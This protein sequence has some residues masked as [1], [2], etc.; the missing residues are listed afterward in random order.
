[1]KNRILQ[2]VIWALIAVLCFSTAC[3]K[4]EKESDT[5]S[6][7]ATITEIGNGSMLVTPVEG[8]AELRS[9]DAFRLPIQNMPPSP[10]PKVGDTVEIIYKGDI[11][12]TYPAGL[13]EIVSI[14]VIKRAAKFESEFEQGSQPIKEVEVEED[15]DERVTFRAIITEIHS[16][17]MLV[18]PVEGSAELR[19]SDVFEVSLTYLPAAPEPQ[20]GDMVEITYNGWINESD[21]AG[22]EKIFSIIIVKEAA[23]V[24][25][26]VSEATGP[27]G[28]IMVDV[29]E[30]WSWEAF[31]VDSDGLTYGQYGLVLKPKDAAGG[32]LEIV[33]S[34]NF[35]VCGTGLKEEEITLAGVPALRGVYDGGAHWDFIIYHGAMDHVVA[36]ALL[37]ASWS[38]TMWEEALQILDTVRLDPDKA[39]GGVWQYSPEC[40]NEAIALVM[41]VRNVSDSGCTV[42]FLQY[43]D[44]G[45][46][47]I[48]GE[49]FYLERQ[50]ADGWARVPEIVEEW[51]FT[52]EGLPI[53]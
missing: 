36:Q 51:S 43:D 10:E 53:P 33:Y 6:F 4:K 28:T 9:S 14:T 16:M 38:E 5:K 52:E 15:E 3:Q 13:D 18:T 1:M 35:A 23:E 49:A 31:P 50:T 40:E 47:T 8:S 12:E 17:S 21:P 45:V 27:Y 22:L 26:D 24:C 20:V 37:C 39:N 30:N 42:H 19:S 7:Q 2:P 46:E 11:L 34:D 48:S 41:D 25:Y 29:P 44:I 32:K